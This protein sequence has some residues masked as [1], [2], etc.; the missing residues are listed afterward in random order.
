MRD[1][2]AG[3]ASSRL[4]AGLFLALL[5]VG[6][7]W[8]VVSGRRH[9]FHLDLRYEHLP[10]WD[11]TQRALLAGK[12]PFWIDGEYCGHPLLFHQEA[13]VFYPLTVPLLLTG[14][15]VAR[16]ADLFSLFHFWLAGF[17]AFLLLEELGTSRLSAVFGGVAWMLSARVLQSAIWPN[18]VATAA[19]LPL[20]LLGI[21]RIGGT[22]RRVSGVL[23]SA[24]SGALMLLAAR[25]HVVVGAAPV[26]LAATAFLIVKSP[27]PKRALADLGIAAVLS[28]A[29]GAPSL[30]PSVALYPE[31]ARFFGLTR[32][33]RDRNPIGVGSGLD[34]VF[35]PVESRTR[36]P[37]AASYPGAAAGILFLAGIGFAFRRDR[38]FPRGLFLALLAG[39]VVGFA[40]SFG[41][42]GPYRF[43]AE[44]PILSGLRVPARYLVSWSLAVALGS[45]LVLSRI[46]RFARRRLIE[47]AAVVVLAADLGWHALRAAP[48]SLASLDS[49]EPD[50]VGTLKVRLGRDEV[51]FPRRFWRLTSPFSLMPFSD[52]ARDAIARRFEPLLEGLGMRFELESVE[53]GGPMLTRTSWLI[54][55]PSERKAMLAGAGCLVTSPAPTPGRLV[56][57]DWTV[58]TV[59]ALPRVILVTRATSMPLREAAAAVLAPAFDPKREAVV[60]GTETLAPNRAGESPGVVRLISRRPGH[61]EL[62]TIAMGE[63][64]LV[65]FDAWESGWRAFVDGNET[66]VF[67]A[68]IAFRGIRL[69]AGTHRVVFDYRPPGLWEGAGVFVAGVLGVALFVIRARHPHA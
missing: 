69:P 33:Q 8:P 62:A 58:K 29:L 32:A 30:F 45:A 66:P 19:L 2:A 24:L 51:G 27:A 35:L 4:L 44:L 63:R 18:A 65:F 67:P 47:G 7:F 40:F 6:A 22:E 11:V 42:A 23:L 26:L 34:M 54:D 61:V 38:E 15:S 5:A 56:P 37:E 12:S 31:M 48:T 17:S 14:S 1:R 52:A 53:G 60:E 9:F 68:D 13:P 10:V 3:F 50:I 57:M 41:E 46:S 21:S 43:L 36:W 16:L 49:V 59:P 64:V 39:G 28:V 55:T 25:P 20:L